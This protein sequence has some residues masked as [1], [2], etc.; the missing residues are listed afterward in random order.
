ML[1]DT[2]RST[3]KR[4]I[5][6]AQKSIAYM[7]PSLPTLC[8]SSEE[9]GPGARSDLAIPKRKTKNAECRIQNRGY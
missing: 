4:R 5:H 9:G 8:V 3:S 1:T 7:H 6:F 2:F